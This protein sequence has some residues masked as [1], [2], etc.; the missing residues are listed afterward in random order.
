FRQA[1]A[2]DS[3]LPAVH[4]NLAIALLYAGDPEAA[5]PEARTAAAGLPDR[6]QPPFVLGLIARARN[7]ADAAEAAFG[8]VLQ[9][10]PADAATKVN[11]GQLQLQKR[12]YPS[13][14]QL[15]R[16][17]TG[18]EPYNA[19]A[20]YGLATALTRAGETAAGRQAMDAFQKLRD[21]P[22]AVTYAQG[23]LQ[24]GRYAEAIASTG[25]E[26]ALVDATSPD[27]TFS[28]A[29]SEV[30]GAGAPADAN[31]RGTVR[32][33]DVDADGDLD[34]TVLVPGALRFFR[35]EGGRVREQKVMPPLPPELLND[36]LPVG[37]VPGDYD[38]D[39]RPDLF[40]AGR[41]GAALLHQKSDG[42]FER[43]TPAGLQIDRLYSTSAAWVDVDHDGDLDM[44]TAPGIHLFRNNGNGAFTEITRAA[45]F[46]A[47]GVA[48]DT[49]TIIPTDF[50]NRRDVDL[51][52]TSSSGAPTLYRNMRDGTFQDAAEAAGLHPGSVTATATAADVNKDGFVDFLFARR[53]RAGVFALSDGRGKFVMRDAPDVTA[54]AIDAQFVDYDNDGLLDLLVVTGQGVRLLR[55]LGARWSDETHRAGLDALGYPSSLALGDLDADGDT[56]AVVWRLGSGVQVWRNDGGSRNHAV[57]VTLAAR[58]SNRS[59][60][61]AKVEIR[62]GSL[63]QMLETS[64]AWPAIGPA[65][66]LFGIGSRDA[67]DVV[68]VLWPSGIL[69]S[70]LAPGA[71]VR[72]EELDRKPSSCPFLYTW[73]GYRFEFVTD[74]LGGGE[75]GDWTGPSGWNTPDPDEYVRITGDQL[76]ARGGRY[77]LRVTNEL[78]EAMFLD[79]TRL[80]VVDHPADVEVYPDEGLTDPPHTGLR[81]VAAR[82]AHAPARAVDEH[83]H[84]VRPLV[85][86]RDGHA[87]DD[88]TRLAVRG[89]AV[90][91]SLTVDAGAGADLLLLTGWTDYAFSNDNVAASQ[92]GLALQ[93]PVVQVRDA[94]GAWQTVIDNLG[95]PV[96]RP[97][98][99]VVDLAG[100]WLGPSR[101]VRIATNMQIHWDQV[102]VASPASADY[103][104]TT[105]DPLSANLAWRG[106]SE[107]SDL[108]SCANVPTGGQP[109]RPRFECVSTVNPWK[110]IPGRYTREGD[111]RPLLARTDDMFVVSMPG[112]EV[113]LSFAAPAPPRAG[114]RRTF[115]LHADGF[116]K[117]MNIRSAT[118]DTLGPLPF[119]KMTR[120]PYGPDEHYPRGRAYEEYL[121]RYNTRAVIRTV[122]SIDVA[123]EVARQ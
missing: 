101:E 13:A 23:Y 95:F 17:A 45:G 56:D 35:N 24:Q 74:F 51:L 29:T 109:T 91:H 12:D 59:A 43:V 33:F 107:E 122:P 26:P 114:W 105:I 71:R 81:L 89:Y 98:T 110:T 39:G 25:A 21:S 93:P 53:D 120:Y 62:A 34:L 108:V 38:N 73:N 61:G 85:A 65:D 113:A 84:D 42:T 82:G 60:A 86:E 119:H 99:L 115:L 37:L 1:L 96:G 116:S 36:Q 67:A 70:E 79:R 27:V 50:D 83:G 49:A 47:Q 28:D 4:L 112:D 3:D 97:Q 22:Y 46:V 104:M 117:E 75:M 2:I 8:R 88:F 9:I 14:V 64:S 57:R 54:G 31:R 11:L 111:V 118:P 18:A 5:L 78:E 52:V 87:V 123:A 58:V 102:Q 20:A 19:T 40:V 103:P 44:V 6:P 16:E 7:D 68:R 69:Q 121:E 41:H 76:R 72:V 106:F 94:H 55:N 48:D 77:E 92:A 80:V 10:D 15:F 66:L 90:P 100:K 30:F 63:R 32:L